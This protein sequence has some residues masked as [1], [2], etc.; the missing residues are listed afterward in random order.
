MQPIHA[1]PGRFYSLRQQSHLC[2][3]PAHLQQLWPNFETEKELVWSP[4]R[5]PKSVWEAPGQLTGMQISAE[6]C[7]QMLIPPQWLHIGHLCGW[8]SVILQ[9][10]PDAGWHHCLHTVRIQTHVQRWHGCVP[11]PQHHAEPRWLSGTEATW[12][13]KENDHWVQTNENSQKHGHT[14]HNSNSTA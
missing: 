1:D 11:R 3:W 9:V 14:M 4:P 12:P 10:K 5:W 8:L 7:R 2:R 13:N 6:T